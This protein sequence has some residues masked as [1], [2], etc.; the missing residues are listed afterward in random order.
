MTVPPGEA[1]TTVASVV[2]PP[3]SFSMGRAAVRVVVSDDA[4]YSKRMTYRLQGPWSSGGGRDDDGRE[5]ETDDAEE[6]E[7]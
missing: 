6:G 7:I 2:V 5:D 4:G 1:V 3:A